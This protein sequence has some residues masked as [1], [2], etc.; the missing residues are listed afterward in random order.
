MKMSTYAY[1]SD[2]FKE[3]KIETND[4]K[5]DLIVLTMKA[6]VFE[7]LKVSP[8]LVNFGM[9]PQGQSESRELIVANVSKKPLKITKIEATPSELFAVSS[10]PFTLKPGQSRKIDV[11]FSPGSSD[12]VVGG[13]VI[14]ETDLSYLTKKTIHVRAEVRA[15]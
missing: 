3:I 4:P 11:K 2:L 12:G 9:V 15:K 8:R 13:N 6:R 5:A 10:E 1:T 14:L 7:T